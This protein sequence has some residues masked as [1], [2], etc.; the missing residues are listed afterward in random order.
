M[1][2]R[3]HLPS[4]EHSPEA[5]DALANPEVM[6]DFYTAWKSTRPDASTAESALCDIAHFVIDLSPIV[7][8]TRLILADLQDEPDTNDGLESL[9]DLL[10]TL[11][12]GDASATQQKI[13][14]AL[15][16]QTGVGKSTLFGALTKD[17]EL[18]RQS[19]GRTG[20]TDVV[21]AAKS[22]FSPLIEISDTPGV[23]AQDGEVHKERAFD[24]ATRCDIVLWV[25][26]N[27]SPVEKLK[28][29][30]IEILQLG[31]PVVLIQNLRLPVTQS[32]SLRS[33][34]VDI[35]DRESADL[36]DRG[37]EHAALWEAIASEVGYPL[38]T[39]LYVHAQAAFFGINNMASD[40]LLRISALDELER[41]I[42]DL[43][44]SLPQEPAQRAMHQ[45]KP[46]LD[47]IPETLG[48]TG[49]YLLADISIKRKSAVDLQHVVEATFD[50]LEKST[51][52]VHKQ[53]GADALQQVQDIQASSR[54]E[55]EKAH[56]LIQIELRDKTQ[57]LLL[58]YRDD[59]QKEVRKVV[60]QH[61]R[62]WEVPLLPSIDGL[63]IPRS[64]RRFIRHGLNFILSLPSTIAMKLPHPAAKAVGFLAGLVISKFKKRINNWFTQKGLKTKSQEIAE[65]REAIRGSVQELSSTFNEQVDTYL[66]EN[67]AASITMINADIAAEE[68]NLKKLESIAQS[69]LLEVNALQAMRDQL[70]VLYANH[71]LNRI[72]RHFD[73]N[74]IYAASWIPGVCVLLKCAESVYEDL[75]L[76]PTKSRNGER[77]YATSQ[78]A[79]AGLTQIVRQLSRGEIMLEKH[80]DTAVSVNFET[81]PLNPA[82]L[83]IAQ[84]LKRIV[85]MNP[86]E[87]TNDRNIQ[88]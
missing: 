9:Q 12:L 28:Q 72:N 13:R 3:I 16:G 24:A 10:A 53:L 54:E 77:F 74:A 43:A 84:N 33:D 80:P 71:A 66:S 60:A 78:E 88:L 35:L 19:G 67:R 65:R 55:L 42:C 85:H 4:W 5:Q 11:K 29:D 34:A 61:K 2:L 40:A 58:Q 41:R 17:P 8:R 22:A 51:V 83:Q 1:T 63:K 18:K 68:L 21:E 69:L 64:F 36:L 57:A 56:D 31:R 48:T 6:K 46:H 23:G 45:I 27:E 30:F 32:G 7:D 73:Q 26:A 70:D 38:A 87:F 82:T 15:I 75:M 59:I 52:K 76:F 50:R 39:T 81:Y 20:Y 49:H 47:T 37:I 86:I 25:T 44:T 14:V 79:L 62:D